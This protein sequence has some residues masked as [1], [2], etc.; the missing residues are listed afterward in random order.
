MIVEVNLPKRRR[1]SVRAGREGYTR[2]LT[3]ITGP[4]NNIIYPRKYNKYYVCVHNMFNIYVCLRTLYWLACFFCIS[5][6]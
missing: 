6:H 1:N 2:D 5:I 4:Q 3:Y